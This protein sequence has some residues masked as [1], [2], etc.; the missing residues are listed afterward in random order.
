[1]NWLFL[2]GLCREQRHWGKFI[3]CFQEIHPQAK[4]HCLDLPGVGT[5]YERSSPTTIH[6]IFLDLRNRWL[7][8]KSNVSGE[9]SILGIS[10]GGMVAMEWMDHHPEDFKNGVLINTSAA[11]LGPFYR[12]FSPHLYPQIIKLLVGNQMEATEKAILEMTT[13]LVSKEE[14][15]LLAEQW[16]EYAKE[17]PFSRMTFL[18][19]IYAASKFQAPGKAKVPTLILKSDGDR[20]VSSTCS[21][22]LAQRWNAECRTHPTAGHDLPLDDGPWTAQQIFEGLKLT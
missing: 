2:R 9:W 22:V 15:Q 8:L 18:R 19:Q 13:N 20:M 5:E 6:E 16:I 1:M 4:V 7:E 10:L 14:K 3:S 11:N 12:R 17:R 21:Q